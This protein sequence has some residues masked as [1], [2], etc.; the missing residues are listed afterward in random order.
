[1][2]QLAHH[3]KSTKLIDHWQFW[4]TKSGFIPSKNEQDCFRSIEL[5]FIT[6]AGQIG[7]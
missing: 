1:M 3:C 4:Q 6:V 2:H 7:L 5:T